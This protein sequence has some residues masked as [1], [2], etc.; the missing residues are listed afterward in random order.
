MSTAHDKVTLE[1]FA[2]KTMAHAKMTGVMLGSHSINDSFLLM[3]TGVGCKYKTASQAAQHD[4][5]EHPNVREAWTQVSEAHL[6]AGCATRIGPFTRAWWERRE[7][8]LFVVVSAYFIELTGDDVLSEIEQVEKDIPDCDM[9][10][11]STV[12]PNGGLFDGY[13]SVMLEV[14]K[15][16][17]WTVT[18]T[19]PRH[20][21][22]YG[23]FHHRHEPDVRADMAQL[24]AL[25][26]AA[27]L[28]A[29]PM[30]FSGC[31]YQELKAATQAKFAIT[32]PYILPQAKGIRRKLKNR[33]II[34][35]DLPI[36]LAGTQRFVRNV[37]DASGNDVR[38]CD[39]WLQQQTQ[40]VQKEIARFEGP[41]RTIT[42]AVFAETPV[43]AGLVTLMREIGVRVPLVG[44]R[45]TKGCLGGKEAFLR[46]L[47]R[48]G[49]PDGESIQI[50]EEPSLRKVMTTV[51]E[52]S[53]RGEIQGI[54]GSSHEIDLFTQ[55]STAALDGIQLFLLEHGFPCDLHHSVF[56][57]PT[58]G[59]VG[60]VNWAQ[61]IYDAAYT[62]KP[63][64]DFGQF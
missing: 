12:A 24:R 30:F 36:G 29:G 5:G 46:T 44:L 15:R 37:A 27:G 41:L 13:A 11:V 59:F 57:Q 43:A 51:L 31:S 54:I 18:P 7:S 56:M 55:Q 9:V 42:V 49:I 50:L 19:Q 64:G 26:K 21:A 35:V 63:A 45:E 1:D 38:R 47:E 58:F 48:N 40:S 4:W 6:V 28:E 53:R 62:S 20:A 39:V 60:V 61:R 23:F 25:V 32:L 17:D 2:L 14:M 52:S 10:Y 34:D 22:I 16:L 8:H 33:T 3:H